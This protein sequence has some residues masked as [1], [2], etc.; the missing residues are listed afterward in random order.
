MALTYNVFVPDTL[1]WS[2]CPLYQYCDEIFGWCSWDSAFQQARFCDSG[3]VDFCF[4]L[5]F[6]QCLNFS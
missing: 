5:G 6:D 4:T 3:K 1:C 2:Q